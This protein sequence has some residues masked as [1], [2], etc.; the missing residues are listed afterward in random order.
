MNQDVSEKKFF[1]TEEA[2]KY[3]GLK[4]QTLANWR[5]LRKGPNYRAFGRRKLYSASDLQSFADSSLI[6]LSQEGG[7]EK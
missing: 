1:S 5:H 7:A 4:P 3:L 6:S 2:A